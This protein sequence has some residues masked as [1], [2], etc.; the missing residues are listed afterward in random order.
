MALTGNT[1]INSFV[2]DKFKKQFGE[3][4]SFRLISPDEKNDNENN[5]VEGLFSHSDDFAK[6]NDIVRQFPQIHEIKLNSI[7]HY[8]ELI[9]FISKDKD[10][11]PIFTKIKKVF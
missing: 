2:I 11:V 1:D 10:I 3:N 5:P 7:E 8:Q 6:L 9:D 4:G